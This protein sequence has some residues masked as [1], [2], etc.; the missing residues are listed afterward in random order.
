MIAINLH[1]KRIRV[2]SALGDLLSERETYNELSEL[3]RKNRGLHGDEPFGYN[4]TEHT[5]FM[6]EG[7][8]LQQT[9][10]HG[11]TLRPIL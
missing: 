4:V 3:W 8:V 7:W 11:E 10:V 5:I 9:N 1:T 6:A 2:Q